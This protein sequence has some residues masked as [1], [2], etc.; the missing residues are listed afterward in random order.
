MS[1]V[2]PLAKLRLYQDGM[3]AICQQRRPLVVDHCH[4]TGLVR[5]LL[6]QRCNTVEGSGID[7]PWIVQYRERPPAAV[8]GLAVK[9][10]KHHLQ[11]IR[12]P[13]KP[14]SSLIQRWI[15]HVTENG[16]PPCPD[17][18]DPSDWG[19]AVQTMKVTLAEFEADLTSESAMD[20]RAAAKASGRQG[21]RKLKLNADQI[22]RAREMYAENGADGKA[23]W[24]VKQIAETFGVSSPT[25]YRHLRKTGGPS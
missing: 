12:K 19:E 10:G 8:L 11:I 25:V 1:I 2:D 22:Q 24:T 9:F 21:G 18:A 23:A 4:E 5:G 6:C 7:Y 3:C 13:S 17:S 15:A 14:R 16:P 20:A